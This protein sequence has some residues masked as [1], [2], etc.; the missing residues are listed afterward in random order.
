MD[1]I[2]L[3]SI[4]IGLTVPLALRV[5]IGILG[6]GDQGLRSDL[7]EKERDHEAGPS[8]EVE[9]R[10][11]A[12]QVLA[13]DVAGPGFGQVEAKH[14]IRSRGVE[15]DG[16]SEVGHGGAE[17]PLIEAGEGPVVKSELIG[18]IERDR[19]VI[20][21]AGLRGI[22]LEV[23]TPSTAVEGQGRGRIEADSLLV[24]LDR[25]LV[26]APLLIRA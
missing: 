23:G 11:I 6:G 2:K 24:V 3:T 21:L 17:E 12:R 4:E 9:P 8:R 7:P 1:Q 25:P 15:L 16:S 13:I 19:L 18:G 22:F 5:W 26:V 14:A 10:G 20:V